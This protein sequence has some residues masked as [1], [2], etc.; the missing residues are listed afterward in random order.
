MEA[1]TIP[2]VYVHDLGCIT[3]V[4]N[5]QRKNPQENQAEN[6]PLPPMNNVQSAYHGGNF[7]SLSLEEN[8]AL[9]PL[10]V[11]RE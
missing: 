5:P 2:N 6:L 4:T 1:Y 11:F 9:L 8:P 10:K 7:P 3:A